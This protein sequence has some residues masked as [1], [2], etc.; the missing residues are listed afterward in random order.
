MLSII[1]PETTA[2]FCFATA[3]LDSLNE[4]VRTEIQMSVKQQQFSP[5]MTA[6]PT[7]G[8]SSHSRV[9]A[10]IRGKSRRICGKTRETRWL[11]GGTPTGMAVE[12]WAGECEVAR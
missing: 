8:M 4:R 1:N 10:N 2:K 12:I 3:G 6:K 7:K 11:S 9:A 5:N